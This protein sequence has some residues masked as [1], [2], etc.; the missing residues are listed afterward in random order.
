MLKIA[1]LVQ[2][3]YYNAT[4]HDML[5]AKWYT[6]TNNRDKDPTSITPAW[7]IKFENL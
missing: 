7:K 6:W 3:G 2:N 4:I 1:L 5:Y